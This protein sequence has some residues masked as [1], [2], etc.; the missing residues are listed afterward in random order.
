MDSI[1][2]HV[3]RR[4]LIAGVA[5]AGVIAALAVA[6]KNPAAIGDSGSLI[7]DTFTGGRSAS[8]ATAEREAWQA[9]V[10]SDFAVGHTR[11]RLAGVRP[12]PRGGARPA[13]LRQ[14]PFIAVFELPMGQALPGNLVYSVRTAR[15]PA[16]DMFLSQSNEAGR[17]LAV[18]N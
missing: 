10:G 9:A 6:V 15:V 16:F 2:M 4:N 11:M 8:L 14:N 18:F 5:A 1:A 3:S 12:L 17:L 13:N 7:R